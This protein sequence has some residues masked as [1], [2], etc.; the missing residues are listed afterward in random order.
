MEEVPSKLREEIG[1][2]NSALKAFQ[3]SIVFFL[4]ATV[5]SD[6]S[7][8]LIDSSKPTSN[9][10]E[11]VLR[12]KFTIDLKEITLRLDHSINCVIK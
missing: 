5:M 8:I 10:S 11:P 3:Y 2:K 4:D 12:Y 6:H 1:K 9:F 7:G